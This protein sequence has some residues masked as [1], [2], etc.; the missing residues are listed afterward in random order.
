MIDANAS[1]PDILV[2]LLESML[3][4]TKIFYSLNCQ[5][6]PEFFEDHQDEFFVIFQKYLNYSNPLLA[7]VSFF[8]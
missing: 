3:L 5:D 7:G 4:S 6:L 2:I 1:Q 8:E